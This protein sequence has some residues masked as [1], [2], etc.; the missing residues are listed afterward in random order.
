MNF[1]VYVDPVYGTAFPK[2]TKLFFL[3]IPDGF[4]H[5]L[6]GIR[7]GIGK[8]VLFQNQ[9][10]IQF[11][12][13]SVAESLRNFTAQQ[14]VDQMPDSVKVSVKLGPANIL[15]KRKGKSG[16]SMI[17]GGTILSAKY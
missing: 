12:F 4:F 16:K 9:K 8:L 7:V 13:Q 3:K 5:Q 17:H 6:K 15:R 2:L 1:T 10:K 14:S 11:N